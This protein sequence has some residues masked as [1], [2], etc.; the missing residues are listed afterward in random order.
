MIDEMLARGFD[1]VII[2]TLRL[3]HDDMLTESSHKKSI[4]SDAICIRKTC[5][6]EDQLS[7]KVFQVCTIFVIRNGILIY[8]R[9]D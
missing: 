6:R 3:I 7:M 8:A 2:I 5:A 1:E 9:H 4:S